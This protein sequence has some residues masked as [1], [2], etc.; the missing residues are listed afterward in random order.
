MDSGKRMIERLMDNGDFKTLFIEHLG[1]DH[2]RGTE[3]IKV[4]AE[5]VAVQRIAHKRGF[6]VFEHR[7]DRTHVQTQRYL[8]KLQKQLSVIAHEHI[9]IVADRIPSVQVWAWA[10]LDHRTGKWLHRMHPS[11]AG[12]V[13]ADSIGLQAGRDGRVRFAADV[14]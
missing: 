13:P 5:S 3:V 4:D 11:F 1:W 14:G 7:T 9:L 10:T 8:R 12:R 6:Q 2:A